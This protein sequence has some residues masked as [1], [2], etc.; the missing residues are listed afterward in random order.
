MPDLV[1]S[2]SVVSNHLAKQGTVECE[3]FTLT[4]EVIVAAYLGVDFEVAV[5]VQDLAGCL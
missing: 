3:D 4:D 1:K 5:A 2:P